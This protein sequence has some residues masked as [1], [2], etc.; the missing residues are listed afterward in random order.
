MKKNTARNRFRIISYIEGFSYLVLMF[1]AMPL[2]YLFD[3]AI[4][5]KIIG[6]THGI[7]FIVFIILLFDYMKKYQIKRD[8]AFDYFIYSLTPFGFYL[9]EKLIKLDLKRKSKN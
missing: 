6:M 5:M 3:N 4:V 8:I 7:L 2:K 9:I 1:I